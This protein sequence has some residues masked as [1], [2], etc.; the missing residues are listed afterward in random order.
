MRMIA[1]EMGLNGWPKHKNW[2]IILKL[3]YELPRG[4]LLCTENTVESVK[5]SALF[6]DGITHI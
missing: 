3:F 1:Q 6:F 5:Y 2:Y 4:Y